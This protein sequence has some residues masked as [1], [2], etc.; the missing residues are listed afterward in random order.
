[1]KTAGKIFLFGII[2]IVSISFLSA[3]MR[4]SPQ[5]TPYYEGNTFVTFP[6]VDDLDR[7]ALGQDFV[8]QVA[9]FGCTPG[10]V[11]S[12]LLEEQNVPVFCQIAA[13]KLNPLIDVGAIESISFSQQPG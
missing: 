9:P 12:D 2:L 13:S 5:Y 6:G 7:C 4:S 3:Y 8:V 1:M 10:V 11:R